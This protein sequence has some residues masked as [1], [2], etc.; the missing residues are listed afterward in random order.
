MSDVPKLVAQRGEIDA[1]LF[2]NPQM[3]VP[4]AVYWSC[5]IDFEPIQDESGEGDED[6][7]PCTLLC[8]WITWP[9]RSWRQID[10]LTLE[11]CVHPSGLEA[12]LYFF[13]VHQPLSSIE[14]SFRGTEGN[15]FRVQGRLIGD[16]EDLE[17][18]VFRGMTAEFEVDAEFLEVGVIPENLNPKPVSEAQ[19]AA[20]LGQYADLASYERPEWV[21]DFKWSFRPKTIV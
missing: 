21:D 16:L 5:R 4:R 14:L 18:H 13:S 6:G 1:H 19:A 3:G 20:A 17:G 7:W 9:I 10:G 15:R 8:E 2:E 12:S 11:N